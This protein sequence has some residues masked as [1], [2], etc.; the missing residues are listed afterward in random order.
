MTEFKDKEIYI[1]WTDILKEINKSMVLMKVTF[2]SYDKLS[3]N[4]ECTKWFWYLCN[5]ERNID[6]RCRLNW[7]ERKDY[8]K[9]YFFNRTKMFITWAY[10]NF[11]NVDK[12]LLSCRFAI[13]DIISRF[14]K[15][16]NDY[17]TVRNA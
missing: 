13:N 9:N 17:S 4:E 11:S 1:S 8:I 6:I 3:Q 15:T 2:G 12:L 7:Y 5:E 10:K 16:S 14:N